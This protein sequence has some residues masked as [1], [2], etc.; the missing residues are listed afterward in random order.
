MV[1]EIARFSQSIGSGRGGIYKGNAKTAA[2]S[3]HI[4][5]VTQVQ[6]V[7]YGFVKFG[8]IGSGAQV[9]N[10]FHFLIVQIK[11]RKKIIPVYPGHVFLI[12]EILV[13]FLIVESIH[14]DYLLNSQ[15]IQHAHQ[16]TPDKTGC[17]CYYYHD[18]IK[19]KNSYSIFVSIPFHP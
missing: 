14:Q 8:C 6:S 12:Q 19:N 9:K 7:E 2:G 10:E 13:F 15:G 5:G 3:E 18:S 4:F 16:V 17:A 11:P 1:I